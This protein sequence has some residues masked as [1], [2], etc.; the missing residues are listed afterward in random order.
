MTVIAF[1]KAQGLACEPTET[2]LQSIEPPLNVGGFPFVLIGVPFVTERAT[3]PIAIGPLPA[4][5]QAR[6]IDLCSGLQHL[7]SQE[8][9]KQPRKPYH[10]KERPRN[11]V[12]P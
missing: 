4:A 1:G 7:S 12:T 9:G 10:Y 11:E 8:R 3:P 6:Y 2:L 5:I